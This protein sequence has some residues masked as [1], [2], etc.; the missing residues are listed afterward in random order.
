MCIRDRHNDDL[1][2]SVD[3]QKCQDDSGVFMMRLVEWLIGLLIDVSW[4][5]AV[6]NQQKTDVQ[7]EQPK[8]LHKT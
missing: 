7:E 6:V 1:H 3:T 8:Q 2:V 5:F 4:L